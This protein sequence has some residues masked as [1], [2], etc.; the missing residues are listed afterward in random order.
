MVCGFFFAQGYDPLITHGIVEAIS[1]AESRPEAE[2][3]ATVRK[4]KERQRN[5]I[6]CHCSVCVCVCVCF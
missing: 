1:T 4:G 6:S 3:I 5:F 2:E